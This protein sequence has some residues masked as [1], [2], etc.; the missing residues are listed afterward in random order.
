MSRTAP[1]DLRSRDLARAI[2]AK[3]NAPAT[4]LLVV[5][6]D[7]P[8]MAQLSRA[9]EFFAPDIERQE[10][11]AWDCQPYD[12]VSP[13]A[14]VVA[15]RMTT[16]SR[17]SRLKGREKP[18]ILLTTVNAVLQRVPAKALVAAQALS[19]A[20]GNILRMDDIVRWLD[21]NG[22]MRASTVREP[23]DYAVRGGII[24]LFPPGMD[25]PVR[26][27]FF[28]DTLESIRSFDAGHP[29]HHRHA[30]ARSIWCRSRNSSSP[31]TPSRNSAWPMWKRSARRRT[32][33]SMRPSARAAAIPAW[34]TGCRCFHGKLDTL[35][36]YLPGTPVVLEPLADDA[37]HERLTQIADYYEARKQPLEA[38]G[39]TPYHPL[40]PDRLYLTEA[41]WQTRR[42]AN[43]V[44]RLSPFADPDPR[45]PSMPACGRAT[46]SRPSARCP[47]PMCSRRCAAMRRRC[48][49]PASAW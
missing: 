18:S 43:A 22:F 1:K 44:V 13:H 25:Q 33:R 48:K 24:D 47:T 31:P 34:N 2:A 27:D 16:L 32:I 5:C 15:Q 45:T 17:L 36:D 40:P 38:A 35:F 26:F 49:P 11:P 46:I 29:A 19:A 6:R 10:F 9:L 23:G 7:G 12:R 37:A 41:E 28:G 3:P 21:L 14:G 39:G 4:S 20:P 42:D 30:C 8:R